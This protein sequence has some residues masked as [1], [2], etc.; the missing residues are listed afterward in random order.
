MTGD[1]LNG[2]A[3]AEVFDFWRESMES[4]RSRLDRKREKAIRDRLKDGYAV[5]DIQL[6]IMGCRSSDF[7]MGQ[8]DRGT[9]FCSIDL[10]CRDAEHLDRF[11]E[12]GEK[13]AAAF[14]AKAARPP[15]ANKADPA[16]EARSEETQRKIDA[17]KARLGR[18]RA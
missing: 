10:I 16:R 6:A 4:P 7:H 3:I 8:N 2:S 15:E 9:R 17:V 1:K 13:A 14:L 18:A 12:L 5:E 11:I